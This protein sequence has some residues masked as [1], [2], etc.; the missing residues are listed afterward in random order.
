MKFEVRSDIHVHPVSTKEPTD[1]Y[2]HF[3]SASWPSGVKHKVPF[4][5]AGPSDMHIHWLING[6]SPD[7]PI[8]EYRQPLGQ[9]EVLVSSW[10]R[11]GPLIKDARYQCVAEASTG[12]DMSDVD[13]LL[14]IGGIWAWKMCMLQSRWSGIGVKWLKMLL[15]DRW[16][17]HSIQGFEPMEKCSHRAQEAAKNMG[18]GLGRF[19]GNAWID[20]RAP[21]LTCSA[22]SAWGEGRSLQ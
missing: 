18:K 21:G 1:K 7:T 8:M 9:K 2:S 6:H 12:N 22:C 15:F 19:L 11:E 20:S 10:L 13:I 3:L 16:G 5:P 14:V 17:E 4:C